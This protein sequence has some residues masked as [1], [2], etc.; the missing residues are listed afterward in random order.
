MRLKRF[1]GQDIYRSLLLCTPKANASKQSPGT[2]MPPI[3]VCMR[4]LRECARKAELR[5]AS[6]AIPPFLWRTPPIKLI[7][8]KVARRSDIVKFTAPI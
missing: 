7:M 8:P 3:L 1:L 6:S 4:S 5:A 2:L